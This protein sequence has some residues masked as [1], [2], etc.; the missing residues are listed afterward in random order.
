MKSY[1]ITDP[2]YYG[3]SKEKFENYL[4]TIYIHHRVDYACFRDKQNK[5]LEE[6]AEIFLKISQKF[7]IE[8]TLINSHISLAKR[9][10]FFGVHLNSKQFDEIYCA[11]GENLFVVIS[12]HSK[13]EALYAQMRGA[14]AISFSPIFETPNKGESKGVQELTNLTSSLG[15]KIFALGGIIDE[16]EVKKCKS[17]GAYGFASIRYFL[18]K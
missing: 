14:D 11:K 10:G 17:S 5:N 1:L 4:K 7:K 12:T 3:E 18:N 8:K 9:R 16:T 2:K 6:F 15:I 13:E